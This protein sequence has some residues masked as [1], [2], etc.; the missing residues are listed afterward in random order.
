MSGK[1]RLQ[2]QACLRPGA[3][4]EAVSRGR[5][6]EREGGRQGRVGGT[7]VGR[8]SCHLPCRERQN[9]LPP[10]KCY[11]GKPASRPALDFFN[12]AM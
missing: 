12:H 4:T 2:A 1:G 6:M 7:T 11:K 3:P 5:G 8:L 9:P 10:M